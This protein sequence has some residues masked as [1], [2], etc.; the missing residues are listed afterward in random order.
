M[1][2]IKKK[3]R[4]IEYNRYKH[5]YICAFTKTKVDLIN[6]QTRNLIKTIFTKK[7]SIS[8]LRIAYDINKE[9]IQEYLVN[10]LK[11]LNN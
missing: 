10:Y 9:E 1:V 5:F 6:Q 3:I 7:N 4:L 2:I 8:L 11:Y